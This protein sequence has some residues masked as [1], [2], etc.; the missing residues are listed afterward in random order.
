MHRVW[1]LGRHVAAAMAAY[2]AMAGNASALP[3]P[4]GGDW[5]FGIAPVASIHPEGDAGLPYLSQPLGGVVPGLVLG[6]RRRLSDEIAIALELGSSLSVE[7]PQ[8]GRFIF[9][10]LCNRVPGCFDTAPS[11]HR[12][13][14]LGILFSY[15]SGPFEMG[16]GPAVAWS[17]THQG[18]DAFLD[19]GHVNFGLSAG[20]DAVLPVGGAGVDRAHRAVPLPLPRRRA[21]VRGNEPERRSRGSRCPIHALGGGSSAMHRSAS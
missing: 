20:L 11:T 21:D 19:P 10:S 18:E 12:D 15:R 6:A 2:G 8:T 1:R 3:A 13:T 16:A 5:S 7:D 14:I 4:D 17:M 9:G